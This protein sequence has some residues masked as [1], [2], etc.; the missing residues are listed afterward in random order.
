M[1]PN[2]N[3]TP[4]VRTGVVLWFDEQR[5]FGF[6]KPTDGSQDVFVHFSAIAGPAGRRNLNQKQF[7]EFQTVAGPKGPIASNVQVIKP[8][9]QT[10]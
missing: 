4:A 6:I 2:S 10:A 8:E 9:E 3:A 1:R 7:V 5:G